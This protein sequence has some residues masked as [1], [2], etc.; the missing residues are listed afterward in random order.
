MLSESTPENT[1]AEKHMRRT[2]LTA[3]GLI[4]AAG[5]LVG[6]QSDPYATDYSAIKKNPSP[7][8][9]GTTERPVDSDRHAWTTADVNLRSAWD[10]AGRAWLF[11]KPTL[12][13]L[14]VY[15]TSG[16]PH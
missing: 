5:L 13:P 15:S 4:A 16:M 6:C 2:A 8:L 1:A 12:S 7:E 10:D 3:A 11:A 14:P 9:R